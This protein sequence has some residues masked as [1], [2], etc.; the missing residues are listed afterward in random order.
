MGHLSYVSFAAA[1]ISPPPP[2]VEAGSEELTERRLGLG[3]AG[4]CE[5]ISNFPTFRVR[6]LRP[7][8]ALDASAV[9]AQG[10]LLLDDMTRR[11]NSIAKFGDILLRD[12]KNLMLRMNYN[13]RI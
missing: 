2:N 12:F 4:L 8:P 10:F 1:T 13:K 6:P 9:S 3:L 5:I 7:R 11:F